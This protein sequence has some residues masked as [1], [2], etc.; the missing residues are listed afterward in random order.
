MT[1]VVRPQPRRL[2][3]CGVNNSIPDPHSCQSPETPS[4]VVASQPF[5]FI[6]HETGGS[7]I[8]R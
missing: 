8:D 2:H 6:S 4:P 5:R 3:D 1:A 7:A